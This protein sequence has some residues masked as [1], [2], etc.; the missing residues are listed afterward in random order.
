M[1]T[2]AALVF[3]LITCRSGE[4]RKQLTP[5]RIAVPGNAFLYLPIFLAQELNYYSEEGI[6]AKIEAIYGGGAKSLQAMLGGS[7]DVAAISLELAIQMTVEGRRVQSF[8]TLIDRPGYVLAVSPA[9]KHKINTVKDLKGGLIGVS[10]PGSGSHNFAN[11]ILRKNNVALSE[12]SFTGIGLGAGAVAAFER[13]QIDAAVLTGNAVTTIERRFPKML[14][15]ADTRTVNGVKEILG[16]DVYPGQGLAA[17]PAWLQANSD[18]ARKLSRALMRTMRYMRENSPE[19]I[20]GRIPAQ[21]R[22][23]DPAADI[24]ALRETVPML[25]A[26]GTISSEGAEAVRRVL[27]VSS[28]KIR[29][30]KFD[31]AATYTNEFVTNH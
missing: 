17:Q 26:N 25:S 16:T 10:S 20:R 15:V 23:A 29:N 27:A 31:L 19:E 21:Y 30:S 9:S 7:V 13:G 11:F 8:L 18:T 2:L 14:I 6:D 12:V 3:P 5:V 22:A 28:E 1:A 4:Q 24:E